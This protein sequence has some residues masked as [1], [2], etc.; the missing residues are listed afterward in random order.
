M[1]RNR[2][3]EETENSMAARDVRAA[4]EAGVGEHV[5]EVR[6]LVKRYPDITAVDGI[7]FDV[8]RGEGF[9]LLG[10]NGAGKT[11]TVEILEGLRD[12]TA[13]EARVLGEDVRSGYRR[14]R[15]RVGVLPQDFEPFDRLR[16]REAVAY[17]AHLFDH[18]VSERDVANIIE[19]V[20]LTNRANPVALNLSGGEKRRLGIAMALV[21]QPEL[22]F[23]DEPTTGLDPGARRELWTLIEDLKRKG[24]T[25]LLTTHYLDEAEQLAD[26][27]A[28]MNHGKIAAR[29][30]PS[31]LIS[32]YRGGTTVALVC[33]G[34]GA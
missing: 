23:L 15:D 26:D 18:E 3:D 29:G 14:I 30:T 2:A 13:G 27:V 28:I 11:T 22:L 16:P 20:G 31:A 8:N 34:P 32:Q 5:I 7:D 10:P 21:G 25:I 1:A 17:W 9:S 12:P 4:R 24:R 19:T 33:A 6:G